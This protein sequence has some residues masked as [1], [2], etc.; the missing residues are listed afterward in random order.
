MVDHTHRLR[1]A[2]VG[3]V[4]PARRVLRP[5]LTVVL[6]SVATSVIYLSAAAGTHGPRVSSIDGP[7]AAPVL[8]PDSLAGLERSDQLTGDDAVAEVD[9]LHITGFRVNRAEVG[10]YGEGAA[11]VWVSRHDGAPGAEKLVERMASRIAA[12]DSRFAPPV[13]LKGSPGVWTTT[14]LGQ[15]HAFFA[16]SGTVWWLSADRSVVDAALADLLGAAA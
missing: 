4:A 3:S 12:S 14:G 5:A 10:W 11:T 8:L 7:A 6:I 2:S 9:G 16:R 13:E 15:T 1:A